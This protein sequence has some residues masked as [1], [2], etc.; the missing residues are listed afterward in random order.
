VR[1][2]SASFFAPAFI[3]LPILF[4]AACRGDG[5]GPGADEAISRDAFVEAYY[6]LRSEALQSPDEEISV[7]ARD[8]I[9]T[10]LGLTE[11]DL[12]GFVEVWG[13]NGETMQGI[14]QEVD[15]LR[16]EDRRAR[17]EDPSIEGY[18]APRDSTSRGGRRPS[19]GTDR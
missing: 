18:E 12:L 3:G 16:R 5:P 8:R 13:D 17:A 6:Q 11:E 19:G 4:A 7:E 14:W 15:S 2:S 1:I 9:L 10:D